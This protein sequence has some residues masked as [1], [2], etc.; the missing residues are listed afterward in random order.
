[1]FVMPLTFKPVCVP[2]I[3]VFLVCLLMAVLASALPASRVAAQVVNIESL[4]V[5]SDA[6]DRL[7]GSV[8]LG[9][10]LKKNTTRISEIKTSADLAW[11]TG[12]HDFLLLSRNNFMR[13]RG[14]NV[15]N[16]GY[17]HLR[18]VFNRS[19]VWA[20]ELFLQG[21]Y[22][23]DWGL[24]RRALAGANV[25]IRLHEA[26]HFSAFV[27]S[28]FMYEQEIWSSDSDR[29]VFNYLKST[30]SLNLRGRLSEHVEVSAIS[31][32]QSR[33]AWFFKPRFTSDWNV[34]FELS[35]HLRLGAHFRATY[36][37]DPQFASTRFIYEL[38]NL[39]QVRF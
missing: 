14:E 17:V 2:K 4:R 28:G 9:L 7:T 11:L 35:R 27:S 30:T 1:M 6:N 3:E 15:L 31:Y 8:G 25:R 24:Q 13:V 32:Y 38:N 10:N 33:P 5:D 12:R 36:D 39:L 22:N 37:S 26:T 16:D 20:P 21:Q 19:N 23:L 29:Q 18:G 34:V